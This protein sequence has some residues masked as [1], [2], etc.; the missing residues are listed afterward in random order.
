MRRVGT[1]LLKNEKLKKELNEYKDQINL[2][3]QKN[4]KLAKE[5]NK[6]TQTIE[7]LNK[8][9]ERVKNISWLQKLF[10]KK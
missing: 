5:N 2:L 3:N 10:G 9:I 8:E 7:S 6:H 4:K 1:I